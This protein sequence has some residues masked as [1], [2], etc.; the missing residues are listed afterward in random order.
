MLGLF[1]SP[2]CYKEMGNLIFFKFLIV[3][4]TCLSLTIY[5][6]PIR[7]WNSDMLNF[8]DISMTFKKHNEELFR[9]FNNAPLQGFFAVSERRRSRCKIYTV[10]CTKISLQEILKVQWCFSTSVS[11]TTTHRCSEVFTQKFAALLYYYCS[12]I[13]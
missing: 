4:T 10:V 12:D 1:F 6:S 5:E 8:Y 9:F 13:F 11:F 7:T 2:V 3:C